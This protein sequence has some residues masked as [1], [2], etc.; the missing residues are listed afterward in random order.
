VRFLE[1]VIVEVDDIL[2]SAHA[3]HQ[4]EL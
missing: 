4:E 3:G 2:I 1:D